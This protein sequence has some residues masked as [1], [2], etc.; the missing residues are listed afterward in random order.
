MS[1]SIVCVTTRDIKQNG[2][3]LFG[4]DKNA[5]IIDPGFD[6][7]LYLSELKKRELS[8]QSILATHGH[9]DH[10]GAVHELMKICSGDFIIHSEDLDVLNKAKLLAKFLNSGEEIKTPIPSKVLN[11][12][13]G[14]LIFDNIE[15]DWVKYPGHTPGS[16]C[17]LLEDNIFLGDLILPKNHFSNRLPGA[18]TQFM[19]LSLAKIADLPNDLTAFPGHGKTRKLGELLNRVVGS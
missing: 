15:I 3:I 11:G 6:P 18:N 8:L 17:F 2:Y 7:E 14:K 5:I 10:I 1:V 4:P 16:I 12:E 19:K 13:S 9:F